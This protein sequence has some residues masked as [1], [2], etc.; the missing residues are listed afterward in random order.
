MADRSLRGMRLGSQSLQ[1]EEG[2]S[3]AQRV[4]HSYLCPVCGRETT[5]VF[6]ADAEAPETWE[7]KYCGADATL[8]VGDSP[9]VLDRGDAKA[10]RSHWDMLL[11]RRSIAELE[12]LLEE[13]LQYLR[14]R[15]GQDLGSE[16]LGA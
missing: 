5:L 3:F 8:L 14:S 11:E 15:R 16:K 1:S 13:R 9:I 2:V 6:A 7:C 10:P 4:S 12:E